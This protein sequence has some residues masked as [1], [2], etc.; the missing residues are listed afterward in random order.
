MRS[1]RSSRVEFS[2]GDFSLEE[3]RRLKSDQV[4]EVRFFSLWKLPSGTQRLAMG[5]IAGSEAPTTPKA[6]STM[7]Q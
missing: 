6:A 7:G 5:L 1:T 2:E 3:C 4:D